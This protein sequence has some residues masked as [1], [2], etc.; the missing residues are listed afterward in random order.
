MQVIRH[1]ARCPAPLT[2]V[3]L[4]LGNFDGVHLGHA[5]ILARARAEATA[6]GGKLAV[7]TFHPHPAAILAPGRAPQRLQS[8]HERLRSFAAAGADVA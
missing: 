6:R 5:A 2:D 3:V 4:T 7:L 8:L 1:L